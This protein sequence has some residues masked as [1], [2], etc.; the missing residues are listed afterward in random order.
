M[1]RPDF[2]TQDLLATDYDLNGG[3]D[4]AFSGGL[5]RES[6]YGIGVT[7]L[8][9]ATSQGVLRG[10][11]RSPAGPGGVVTQGYFFTLTIPNLTPAG[12][13][14]YIDN[15]KRMLKRGD[16]MI[17][18]ITSGAGATVTGHVALWHE[19]E[20]EQPPNT[21]TGGAAVMVPGA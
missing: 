10:D 2:R 11:L 7:M 6:I 15:I 14:V 21:V 13:V 12:K 5:A 18:T 16:E 19:P 4:I 20:Y 3:A 9:A 1:P 17:I 8:Q